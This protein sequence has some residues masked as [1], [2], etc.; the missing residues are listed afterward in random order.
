MKDVRGRI[1]CIVALA[2]L[3]AG[4][5]EP[6]TAQGEQVTRAPGHEGSGRFDRVAFQRAE[7]R[8]QELLDD[9]AVERG[10]ATPLSVSVPA[11]RLAAV[12]RSSG[13][14]RM[15]GVSQRVG[16]AAGFGAA[17]LPARAHEV[18]DLALGSLRRDAGGWT[19]S[20]AVT[21]PGATAVRL[22]F[23]GAFVPSGAELWVYGRHGEAHGPYTGRGPSRRGQFWA[24]T[25]RGE[26]ARLQLR[27]RGDA[28]GRALREARLTVAEVGHLTGRFHLGRV[29]AGGGDVAIESFCSFN[30]PCVINAECTNVPAAI[31]PAQDAVANILFQSGAFL[32]ICS[33][34]LLADTDGGSQIPY[35][36]TAN[37]CISKNNEAASMEAFFQFTTPCNGA[38]YDP[39]GVVPSTLGSVI[40]SKGTSADYTLLELSEPAPPGSAFLGWNAGPVAFSTGAELFRIS[41]PAG[42]PQAYS[43]QEVDASA[44]TC[45][46]WPR[47][48][49]IYSRDTVGGTEGG[50][51]GSPVLNV[52]GEVV[53]QLSGACGTNVGDPC[54]SVNNATVDG[55]FAAYFSSVEQF[56]DPA[57]GCTDADNDLYCAD[58]DCNDGDPNVN[59]G[60]T[61]LCTNGI[62]DD[63]DGLVDGAD[64]DCGGSCSPAG[65]GCSENAE[66][67]SNKCKGKPGSQICR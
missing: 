51:S 66:C 1:L 22:R 55:A 20:A 7:A 59:P 29:A 54:D 19:W 26:T 27:Y 13:P 33:G 56:L 58:V 67:C 5:G 4:A 32:Y 47:G 9:R 21:S 61:E 8:Q 28:P 63:C 45:G 14:R 64:P 65:A 16:V 60:A 6:V 49:R 38:C 31:Q 12:E 42:A 10:L 23:S 37:H 35:F 2:V 34:G 30:E 40:R 18:R 52:A 3:S 17:G 24:H 36:L 15:V 39:D 41:H 25:V 46:G 57:G 44:P 50:S 11:S 43:A 48:P 53:G 62:D